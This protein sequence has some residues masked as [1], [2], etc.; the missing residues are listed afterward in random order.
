MSFLLRKPIHGLLE[1]GQGKIYIYIFI[2]HLSFVSGL[3]SRKP[4]ILWSITIR[5]GTWIT[6]APAVNG[7]QHDRVVW[8]VVCWEVRP[9]SW[10]GSLHCPSNSCWQKPTHLGKILGFFC[11]LPMSHLASWKK[12]WFSGQHSKNQARWCT[13]ISPT[14][15]MW[16]WENQKFEVILGYIASLK[17]AWAIG[18]PVYK[19]VSQKMIPF[20]FGSVTIFCIAQ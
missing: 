13:P 7:F 4:L 14:L 18:D 15:Q 19:E 8:S 17:S 3:Q 5:A 20:V 9:I 10:Q 11:H 16:R 6:M 1:A 2:L 12:P